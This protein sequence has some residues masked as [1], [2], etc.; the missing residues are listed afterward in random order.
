MS[1]EYA[2]DSVPLSASK[3][4]KTPTKNYSTV[5]DQPLQRRRWGWWDA[6]YLL[7]LV[8][9]VIA[10]VWRYTPQVTSEVAGE[11]W[12]PLLNI[13]TLA[14]NTT[15]LLHNPAHLW[16]AQL[17]YPNPLTLSYSENLL[18]ETIF[19]A[20]IFL[21]THNP[22]LSYNLVFYFTFILCGT[23]MYIL[24]RHYTGSPLAAFV[25]GLIFA[26]SPYRIGQIDHI[27]IVAG[28]WMPLALLYFARALSH[29]RWRYWSLF[30]LCYLLQLLSSIYYGIFLTYTLLAYLLIR[31][32]WPFIGQWRQQGKAYLSALLRAALKPLV[33]CSVM[34][35]LL[36]VLLAPYLLSLS[37]GLSR[38]LEQAATFSAYIRDFTFTAPFNWL[39]GLKTYNGVTLPYDS[40]H[41]LFPGWA[42]LLLT[43]CGAFLVLRKRLPA[44]RAY[45]WVGLI[46]LLFSLG[47]FLQ[48]STPSG[49]PYDPQPHMAATIAAPG[50]PMPWTLAYYILP[51]FKG[52][53]VPA[54]LMGVLLIIMALLA[55]YVIAYLESFL[56]R[57]IS[58]QADE[59]NKQVELTK[60]TGPSYQLWKKLAIYSLLCCIPLAI[61][62]EG[63]PAYLP[64]THVPSG[65]QIPA[66]YQWLA[67]HAD[68]QP[69]VELPMAYQDEG[70]TSKDEAWYDYYAI[71]HSHPIMNG[72][73]GYRPPL[74]V[75]IAG[76][77]IDFPSSTSLNILRKYQVHY[78]ILHLQLYQP[79]E[80]KALLTRVQASKDLQ[81]MATFGK[82][83][84]WKV[85]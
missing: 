2:G 34:L 30:A 70:F 18:G 13:W 24:A 12:D 65:D 42:A 25:A 67:T 77:L 79:H 3:K 19:F 10:M 75:H 72:W 78:V 41:Y 35:I 26:F 62:L 31:Y 5:T 57:K 73:S 60:K 20:P 11:W 22:V 52:L 64:V 63:S 74:T 21:L 82:D 8:A 39:Y 17:L 23:N 48:F 58:S 50:W 38:S 54:R 43:L 46:I 56:S 28:E 29:N 4:Q 33:V 69:L 9:L 45:V 53:R 37:S 27:H 49:A 66:V 14:W 85:R 80:A 16:Q 1:T 55:A 36:A 68:E 51:G 59:A 61:I 7:L 44:M 84:I 32:T 40:E 15:T 47:P 83:S 81:L 71:Y 6:V 76:Q